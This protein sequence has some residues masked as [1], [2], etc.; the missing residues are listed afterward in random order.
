LKVMENI[1]DE[2]IEKYKDTSMCEVSMYDDF[3]LNIKK[4]AEKLA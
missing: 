3:K 1:L 4:H 2:F